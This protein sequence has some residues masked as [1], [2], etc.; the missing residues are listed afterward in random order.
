MA[1]QLR[2]LRPDAGR[3]R[4]RGRYLGIVRLCHGSVRGLDRR[5]PGSALA[6]SPARHRGRTGPAGR[7]V[8][9]VAGRG[10]RLP[11]A[12]LG[13]ERRRGWVAAP[14]PVADPGAGPSAS[15]GASTGAGGAGVELRRAQRPRQSSGSLPDSAWR[16]SRCA[17]G[18]RRRALAGHGGRSAGD[19]QGRWCLC[20]AGP[21]LSAGPFASHARGQRRRPVAQPGAFA[22]RAAFARRAGGALHRPPGTGR[23]GVHG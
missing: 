1:E 6:E 12:G 8:A 4:G 11:V 14:G 9:A 19:P 23:I 15:A 2:G 7:R 21:D 17:G 10:A 22:A 3:A 13:R 5:A 20:A 18:N 16:R